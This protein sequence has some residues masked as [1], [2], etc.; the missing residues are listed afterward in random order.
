MPCKIHAY[1]G[2]PRRDPWGRIVVINPRGLIDST[3]L[4]VPGDGYMLPSG[5]F[6]AMSLLILGVT[7]ILAR[8]AA[9]PCARGR[10]G[11]RYP[12]APW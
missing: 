7:F 8:D 3:D 1:V 10:D 12:S 5:P 2:L 11:N 9:F 6:G 4:M